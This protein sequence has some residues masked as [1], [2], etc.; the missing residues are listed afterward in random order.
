MSRGLDLGDL[1]SDRPRPQ[2]PLIRL[3]C[4]R[5]SLCARSALEAAS[6]KTISD[7]SDLWSDKFQII[8]QTKVRSKH[9]P[10][11]VIR[12]HREHMCAGRSSDQGSLG[13]GHLDLG[14]V[15]S[16]VLRM[17]NL[18]GYL[19]NFFLNSCWFDRCKSCCRCIVLNTVLLN[20][21]SAWQRFSSDLHTRG[22]PSAMKWCPVDSMPTIKTIL[23]EEL[24]TLFG[25]KV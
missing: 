25:R 3:V 13:S 23:G 15:P 5:S 1:W 9:F 20:V 8:V 21:D 4:A 19:A 14:T 11:H 17:S 16:L 2:W 12:A 22:Q 10:D 24:N 6:D 18:K 7:W